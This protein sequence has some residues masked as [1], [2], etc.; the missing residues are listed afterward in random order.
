MSSP[1]KIG[2]I[3]MGSLGTA[4]A[5]ILAKNGHQV[6][7]WAHSSEVTDDINQNHR[8]TKYFPHTKL[9]KDITATSDLSQITA[10][11]SDTQPTDNDPQS[12]VT[13]NYSLLLLCVPSNHL[14]NTLTELSK[15]TMSDQT[16]IINTA[17]GLQA[18]SALPVFEAIKQ[19]FPHQSV[20]QISGPMI[21]NELIAGNLTAGII[22]CED[23]QTEFLKSL[24]NHTNLHLKFSA[25]TTGVVW[26]GILKNIYAIGVGM[27]DCLTDNNTNAKGIYLTTA[28][29]EMAT[30][31]KLKE[32]KTKTVYGIAGVGDLIT[33]SLSNSSHNRA[34]GCRIADQ[35]ETIDSGYQPEGCHTLQVFFNSADAQLAEQ[36]PLAF[37]IYQ[38][39][40]L[41]L[42][43]EEWYEQSMKV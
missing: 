2:I 18:D 19:Q 32:G 34:F 33:T 22:A 14:T 37:L 36:L 30:F 5:Q 40:Q 35:P 27:L 43:L 6:M 26:C 9:E 3:G 38:Y 41:T 13:S 29:T 39:T 16:I 8:N 23:K 10:H 12:L 42:S 31:L 11:F 21:A 25:D 4:L 24:F 15:L 1:T 17:K 7:G 28:L 20:A